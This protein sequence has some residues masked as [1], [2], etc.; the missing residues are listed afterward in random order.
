MS[1]PVEKAPVL[2]TMVRVLLF[3]AERRELLALGDRHLAA[4]VA[5]AAVVGMGRWWDD[6]YAAFAQRLGL[7]SIAYVFVLAGLVW[8]AF[9]PW[10][11][12]GW[13]YRRLAAFIALTSPPAILYALPIERVA[14]AYA[15][16][17]NG[18]A[19]MLV[20]AWRVALLFRYFR[21]F[22]ELTRGETLIAVGL[23]VSAIAGFLTVNGLMTGAIAIMGGLREASAHSQAVASFALMATMLLAWPFPV[24]ALAYLATSWRRFRAAPVEPP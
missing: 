19:L 17:Y 24:L 2:S 21:V 11:I 20:A 6:P 23:P 12:Q 4:G 5:A 8:F 16:G 13:G 9:L 14:P 1:E 10:R 7:G 3:R 18:V 15:L 22:G